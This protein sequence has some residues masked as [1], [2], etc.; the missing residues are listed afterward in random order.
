VNAN[1][2][3]IEWTGSFA[4]F[5][6]R[7]SVADL[8]DL[9]ERATREFVVLV[10]NDDLFYVYR[11]EEL[12][13]A[14]KGKD[15]AFSVEQAL[16]IHEDDRSQPID[17]TAGPPPAPR[18][19]EGSAA[20]SVGRFVELGSTGMPVKVGTLAARPSPSLSP[21]PAPEPVKRRGKKRGGV[22]RSTGAPVPPPREAGPLGGAPEQMESAPDEGTDVVRY[23]SVEGHR[24]PQAGQWFS[25][26]VDL[27]RERTDLETVGNEVRITSLPQEWGE[28]PIR[29]ELLSTDLECSPRHGTIFV[30]RNAASLPCTFT[31][32]LTE[33]LTER[34]SIEVIATFT[35]N[36][37]FCGL[38]RKTIRTSPEEKPAPAA[39]ATAEVSRASELT[40]RGKVFI[41]TAAESP[42]LTVKIFH[43]EG[44]AQGCY[45]W[46]LT[47]RQR[48]DGLPGRLDG[49]IVLDSTAEAYAR[50]L[51]G[52]LADLTPGDHMPEFKG[53]G[54][55]L[56]ERAP[57]CFRETY[58]AMRDHHGPH[59][60]I[61]FVSDDP[62]VPWELMRPVR[63]GGAANLLIVDHPVARWIAHY[64]GE[65]RNRLPIGRIVTIAPEYRSAAN[66]LPEAQEEAKHLMSG[67]KALRVAGSK[68]AVRTFL[69]EG[70]ADEPVA[71]VH[72]AGHGVY[73][74]TFADASH[75]VLED[76]N[77][78][79]NEVGSSD[80]KLGEKDRPLVIF[81]ACEVGA[82]GSVLGMVGGWAEVFTRRKFGGFFAPLWPVADED[83][84]TVISE[85]VDAVWSKSRPVGE[86]L[87][88]I[89]E[90]HGERSP[91]FLSYL[92]YGDVTA[93]V[94]K[95]T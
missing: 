64:D 76:G 24:T 71:L 25:V 57:A 82:V 86:S 56:W 34:G 36:E 65:M 49:S 43:P 66:Q 87:R 68:D 41:E 5:H 30:R 12:A 1:P 33:G 88:S 89:R 62:Y 67:F 79:V 2:A 9:L 29:V 55:T 81:N 10:R 78:S 3:R 11:R 50:A 83:A 45:A 6:A 52:R 39:A 53:V 72:F 75:I 59:F 92:Y 63:Q 44:T 60:S 37:R 70:L 84:A 93:R 4:L 54:E 31:C 94:A 26:D 15:P 8:R 21:A 19:A 73:G 91:T 38:A 40:T 47:P 61:Q 42:D 77:L 51:F 48:F 17:E 28:I 58:W 80:V 74:S 13:T 7:R 35:Y 16:Q 69:L 18:G 95:A 20:P 85:L 32:K 90:S 23:P 27:L 22:S 46:S 14:L